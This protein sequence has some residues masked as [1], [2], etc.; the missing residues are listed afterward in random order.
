MAMGIIQTLFRKL[1]R[2]NALSLQHPIGTTLISRG[3]HG[4]EHSTITEEELP[5]KES[6]IGPHADVPEG[7]K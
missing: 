6:V 4:L 2:E 1:Q 7:R 5:S 3:Q